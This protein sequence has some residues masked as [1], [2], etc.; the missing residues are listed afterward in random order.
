MNLEKNIALYEKIFNALAAKRSFPSRHEDT[1]GV[2]IM[3]CSVDGEVVVEV[4]H[5]S[6]QRLTALM[7][8]LSEIVRDVRRSC[9]MSKI[10]LNNTWWRI[11]MPFF[12]N[13]LAVQV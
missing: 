7:N 4:L 11:Q 3:C 12:S 9:C 8:P 2:G 10:C 13:S 6:G 5:V 1:L